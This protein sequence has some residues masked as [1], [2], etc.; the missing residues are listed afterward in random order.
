MKFLNQKG[1]FLVE[2]V[3]TTAIITVVLVSILGLIQNS[4]EASQRSLEF[5]QAGYLLE[6]G[7]ESI[8]S[9]RDGVW[10][11]IT[12]LS[13]GTNYYLSWNGSNWSLS[14]TPSTIGLF[15]RIVTIDTVSRDSSDDITLSGGTNDTGTKKFSVAITWNTPS[16]NQSKNIEFYISD[17]RS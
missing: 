15:T 7:V 8:K 16:G 14:T 10:T 11:N 3:V 17:I 9:I 2:V 13:V 12:A 1:F 6:E 5:T 4:V